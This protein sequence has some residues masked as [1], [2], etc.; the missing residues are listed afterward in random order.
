MCEVN[1]VNP[2]IATRI[3]VLSML[4]YQHPH[5]CH[6][7]MGTVEK[8]PYISVVV[9]EASRWGHNGT[10]GCQNTNK[11]LACEATHSLTC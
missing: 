1:F 10:I 3:C 6:W 11:F 4:K 8:C 9:K 2:S 7:K 5:Y